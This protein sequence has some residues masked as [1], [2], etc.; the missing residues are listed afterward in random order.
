MS[1]HTTVLITGTKSGIGKGLLS[2]YA[3]RD[4]HTVIAAI[5]D[6]PDSQPGKDLIALPVGKGSKIIIAKYDAASDTSAK[7][8]ISTLESKHSI[9]HLD[10]V[11]ANA[12]ILKHWGPVR[13]VKSA[14]LFEHFDI[15]VVGTIRL[16]QATAPLL[17]KSSQTPKFFIISSSIGSN[18]LMDQY[19]PMKM[20]AYGMAKSSQNYLASRIHREEDKIV[21]VPVQPGWVQ[22]D[23]G[24]R[25]AVY[26]GMKASDPPVTVDQSV[27]GM[28]GVFDSASKAEYSGKF[29]NQEHENLPW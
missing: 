11:I 9:R 20:I 28:M 25:A 7:E 17:D 21:V 3:L 26:A 23:M 12:G 10:I 18:G 2:A 5:R 27:T 16:F 4:H 15:H 24:S 22:T 8:M 13:E 1:A 29:W 14:D 19:A 6:G